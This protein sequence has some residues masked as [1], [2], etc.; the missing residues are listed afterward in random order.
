MCIVC[1]DQDDRHGGWDWIGSAGAIQMRVDQA[2]FCMCGLKKT[3][4]TITW[5]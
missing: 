3:L 1:E 4:K 5:G 2:V